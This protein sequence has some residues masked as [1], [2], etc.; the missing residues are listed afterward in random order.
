[1][2]QTV[3]MQNTEKNKSYFL[4][5]ENDGSM[6]LRNNDE[7]GMLVSSAQL[8]DMIDRFFEKEF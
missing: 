4:I 6:W 1:M 2:R 3:E 5:I 7:E 8:F